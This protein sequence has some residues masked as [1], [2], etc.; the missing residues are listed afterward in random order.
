MV[1]TSLLLALKMIFPGEGNVVI[2]A[3]N[4]E[5]PKSTPDKPFQGVRPTPKDPTPGRLYYAAPPQN[6][7]PVD[8]PPA[9]PQGLP[10]QH[11]TI[12]PSPYYKPGGPPPTGR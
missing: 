9:P 10:P 3:K 5:I 12:A 11:R 1:A 7:R 4:I 8:R 6:Y 2:V